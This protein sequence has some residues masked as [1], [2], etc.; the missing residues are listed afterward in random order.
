MLNTLSNPV[1]AALYK[2]LPSLCLLLF[3]VV[4]GVSAV[5]QRHP[6]YVQCCTSLVSTASRQGQ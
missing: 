3:L 5:A 1:N 2:N 6:S 4:G